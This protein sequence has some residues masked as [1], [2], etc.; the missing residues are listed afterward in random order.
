[1]A[2]ADHP[3]PALFLGHGN[4]MNALVDTP[5]SLAWEELGR[6][7]PRPRAILCISAHWETAGWLVTAMERPRTIHDFHGFPRELHAFDYPAPGAP[8]LAQR[9]CELLEPLNVQGTQEWGLDHGAWGVLCRLHPV[10]DVPVAQ[11]SLNRQATL[12]DFV[13]LGRR[14]RPL[15]REGV[16]ILGSG[17]IVHHLGQLDWGD[18][19]GQH[20]KPWASDFDNWVAE[21]ALA[22]G[23]SALASA[24]SHPLWPLAAPTREHFLPLLPVLGLREEGERTT[25][26]CEG[27]VMGSLSMRGVCIGA[28]ALR[29]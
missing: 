17:N 12:A 19:A 1:M 29:P 16:L 2:V 24:E 20:P 25:F 5:H 26:P 21:L 28:Q 8:A 22:G 14:L 3:M 23:A 9:V 7:L 6:T 27:I 4:P 11:L 13:D 18:E 10:A 15:R